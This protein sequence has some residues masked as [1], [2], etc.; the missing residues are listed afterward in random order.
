MLA[1]YFTENA[2][3]KRIESL[4]DGTQYAPEKLSG[5]EIKLLGKL[6]E[7]RPFTHDDMPESVLC[8]CPPEHEEALRAYFGD[9]FATEMQAMLLPATLDLRV[10][11][12][13][14][15]RDS[16]AAMLEKD[17]VKT[18]PTP[19]SPWG[20]RCRHKAYLA[21][22]KAMHK[23]LIEIQDEGSQL[24]AHIC[25]AE[26]GMQ[27]LDFCAG[28]GGKTLALAAAMNRKG[29]IVAADNDERRLE[30]GRRRY[31][32]AQ[33]A[34]MIEI[35]PLSEERHRKWLR[36]QKGSFD[37]VLT[38]VPCSGTGTWRRNPD[39]RWRNFGP[40]LEA[41]LEVQADIMDKAAGAVKEG[42]KLVYATCSILPAENE[43]QIAAFL[44]R[45]PEFEI[46]PVD[47]EKG[48]GTPYMR[49][50]PH[51]H[52]TD[53]FFAAVLTRRPLGEEAV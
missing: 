12:F 34:D 27:V 19:H 28:G 47:P 38:D 4:F 49:L 13:L 45:N 48:L 23:G 40:S 24:I 26:P 18:E 1:L 3:Q 7:N 16:V 44:E 14:T 43:D 50:T 6:G 9:A 25:G 30:R 42:G 21:K 33:L 31:K 29:R 41:L 11:T 20:L 35:R 39:T 37:V 15:D 2:D 52:N 32:K 36:R 46:A 53:G 8:E 22:T 5:Y 10:N 51:R 17:G